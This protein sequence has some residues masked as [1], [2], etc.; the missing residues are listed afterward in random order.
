MKWKFIAWL[1]MAWM[2]MCAAVQAAPLAITSPDQKIRL[3][4]DSSNGQLAY[5]V[6]YRGKPLMPAS[7]LGMQLDVD[8]IRTGGAQLLGHKTAS[9]DATWTQPWG[10][11]RRIRNH[12]RELTLALQTRA[13][14]PVKFNLVFRVFD[15]GIGFRYEWPKQPGLHAFSV[16]DEQTEFNFAGNYKTWSIPADGATHYEMLYKQ[17]SLSAIANAHTPL[18]METDDGVVVALHEAALVD[19]PAMML[20]GDG[21]NKLHA[22]LA[23]WTNGPKAKLC[24][25]HRS[26]WRT[27]QIASSARDLPTSYMMLNLNEPNRLGDVSWIKPAKYVGVW[28]EIHLDHSTWNDDSGRHGARTENVMKYIDFAA[29]NGLTGVLVEGWNDGWNHDWVKQGWRNNFT[30][31]SKNF[32]MPRLAAYAAQKGVRIIGHHETG[33]WLQNYEHQLGDALDYYQQYGVNTIKTGYVAFDGLNMVDAEGKAYKEA[34]DGQLFVNHQQKVIDEAAKRHIMIVAHEPIKDTGLRRTYP[35]FLS[36]EGARG[37]EFNAWAADG[38]NPPEHDV[39]LPF[40]RLLAAPMDFTPGIVQLTY[41]KQ[42]PNNRVNTTLAKQLALYVTVYSPVQM[43]TDLPENYAAKPDAF[44][45][46]KDVPVDWEDTRVLHAQVG[47][48]VTFVRKDS[49]SEDW[50]LGSITNEQPRQLATRFDFLGAGKTW[51]AEIYRDGD[52][53]HWKSNPHAFVREQFLVTSKT[54]YTIR[55]AAGGGQAIRF[56]P[57]LAEDLLALLPLTAL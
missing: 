50:Y 15:D 9:F 11:V 43:V 54:T 45:F 57:A 49:G 32:D 5:R 14:Q 31:A 18:T 28:W 42:R 22:E 47:G 1:G 4:I 2:L 16:V 13:V 29:A 35:N 33:G 56:R 10:E 44:R 37:Q 19:F 7:R 53:A 40:T 3:D 12:Y 48:Y 46:I 30:R 52:D 38:G 17:A 23:S 26:S 8:G 25:P 6:T 41:E 20:R 34:H 39:I 55:L 36:R 27:I 51:V 24:A 21:S